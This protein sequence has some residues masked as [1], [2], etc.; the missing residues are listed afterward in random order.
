MAAKLD[1]RQMAIDIVRLV[2]GAE[3]VSFLGH[4]MTR[5]RFILKDESRADGEAIKNIK[6]VLGVVS[7]GGQF[8]VILGQNLVPVYEAAIKEFGLNAGTKTTEN[9][10]KK[11][12]PLTL[13]SA[14]LAAPDASLASWVIRFAVSLPILQRFYALLPE[15]H[16]YNPPFCERH[17]CVMKL[18]HDL[19][20]SNLLS[21]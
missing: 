3:N 19:S 14:G 6:G 12:E 1:Y 2:G 7:A 18:V 5:L 16:F 9:L 17:Q 10:D 11:K 21:F 20:L 13:K 8:M 4:C 15:S